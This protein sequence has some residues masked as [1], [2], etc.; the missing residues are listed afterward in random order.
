MKKRLISL[1]I[2]LVVA[3]TVIIPV[4]AAGGSIDNFK[5]TN[6]YVCGQFEDVEISDWFSMYVQADYE[7][8][9]LIGKT[10]D[11]FAPADKLTVAKA[12][13]IVVCLSSIY[14]HSKAD[15][16]Q[17]SSWY[18]PYE[19]Y[20]LQYGIL[21]EPYTDYSSYIT[22]QQFAELIVNALPSEAFEAIND[23]PDGAIPDVL[24]SDSFGPVVYMLY[25][26][27]VLTGC[28][29][30]G[31]F[32]PSSLLSRAEAAAIVARAADPDFRQ[33]VQLT[34]DLSAE[35]IYKKCA[36]AVFYIERYDS[37]GNLLGV[38]SGFFITRDGLALTNYHVIDG[39]ASAFIITADGIVYE[40]NGV[41]GYNTV[42]DLAVL[43]I[44][45]SGFDY[46]TLGD[47]DT[48]SVGDKIYAIGSPYGLINT[49]SDGIVS[50]TNQNLNESDFIQF[51]APISLGSG[52]GPVLNTRG[53]VV[54]LTCLT[55][56]QGQTLNFAVPINYAEDLS[57][58]DSVPLISVIKD[59]SD[60]TVY[61]NDY[62]PVP[63]YGVH[64][65]ALLYRSE[66]DQE[67]DVKT[68]FYEVSE[69]TAGDEIAVDGYIALL[70]E[71][72]FEWQSNLTSNAG[73][74]SDIYYNDQYNITVNFGVDMLDGVECRFV[75]IY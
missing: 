22:R 46:L 13:K 67:T 39:A 25:E 48:L 9:L 1:L 50:N 10:D 2:V 56:T 28:D 11:T 21:S 53:Q 59:N 30:Y 70:E 40:V 71:N 44:D 45:G 26:A 4:Q 8:G 63:D 43:Q 3:A 57:R 27:G 41:C 58:T 35:E 74:E 54:G 69:I 51:S 24:R 47:S 14:Y 36:S 62:F 38:G 5:I 31:T 33:N 42:A 29:S 55:A 15:F 32:C 23:V 75:A 66:L 16:A 68:Y 49:F 37:E 12:V 34:S 6:T 61:Y 64:V 20:A 17:T 60:A 18:A 52:G 73:N 19:D 65:G 7:Y 72:G